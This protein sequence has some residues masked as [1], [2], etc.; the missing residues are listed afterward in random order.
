MLLLIIGGNVYTDYFSLPKGVLY[1][2]LVIVFIVIIGLCRFLLFQKK[3]GEYYYN[4]LLNYYLELYGLI[5][6]ILLI[7]LLLG[8]A[9][10]VTYIFRDN[11]A[12]IN[13]FYMIVLYIMTLLPICISIGILK[14]VKDNFDFKGQLDENYRTKKEL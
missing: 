14:L 5:I 6:C 8:Y 11:S 9:I 7:P 12:S 1:Y 4:F 10:Y 13:Q 2:C 3:K